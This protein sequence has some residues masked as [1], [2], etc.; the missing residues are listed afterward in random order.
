[1]KARKRKAQAYAVRIRVANETE[2]AYSRM[3]DGFGSHERQ[4]LQKRS[5]NIKSQQRET[6][7]NTKCNATNK[8]SKWQTIP[9]SV[10]VCVHKIATRTF[11]SLSFAGEAC[12][13]RQNQHLQFLL[14]HI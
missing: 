3:S 4:S 7:L 13:T 1:M 11:G 2:N 10:C 9:Q 12:Y 14:H 5:D 6:K 8:Y